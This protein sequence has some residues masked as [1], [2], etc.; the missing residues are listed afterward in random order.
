MGSVRSTVGRALRKAG[1]I[2]PPVDAFTPTQLAR[3]HQVVAGEVNSLTPPPVEGAVL[4]LYASA[5][6]SAQLAVDIFAG[7][8][9]SQF[10]AELNVSSGPLPLFADPRIEVTIDWLG[11]GVQGARVLELGPLEG[12]HTSML[13]R[14]GADVL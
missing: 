3:L 1:V 11:S 8:W 9:S 4:D 5:A 13:D 6:P 14:A 12:A 10:P 2:R 7:E